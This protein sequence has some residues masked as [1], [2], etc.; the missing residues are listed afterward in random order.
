MTK[1]II[2]RRVVDYIPDAPNEIAMRIYAES[3]E[4]AIEI[5][6]ANEPEKLRKLNKGIVKKAQ[7][8]YEN[9]KKQYDEALEKNSNKPVD[10]LTKELGINDEVFTEEE[11]KLDN[12]IRAELALYI[13]KLGRLISPPVLW[14]FMNAAEQKAYVKLANDNGTDA[15]ISKNTKKLLTRV[16]IALKYISDW[17]LTDEQAKWLLALTSYTEQEFEININE[18]NRIGEMLEKLYETDDQVQTYGKRN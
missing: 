7:T 11:P 14:P 2:D 9:A 10:I 18:I 4:N 12:F 6:K 1:F 17:N 8:I 5:I 15:D 3:I 13:E 16:K